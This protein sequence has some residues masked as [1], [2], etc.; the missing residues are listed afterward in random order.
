VAPVT[1]PAITIAKG[2]DLQTIPSG[3]TA[4]WTIT[5]TNSGDV[6]LT[7]V[8]VTDAEAPGCA[9][10]QADLPAL[11]SMAPGA[12]VSYSCSRANVGANFTNVAVAT[13]TPSGAADVTDDDDARV[14][15]LLPAIQVMKTPDSQQIMQGGTATF[16]IA[17]TNTGQVTLTNV[18]V[19]DAQAPGCA[20]TQ[21][22]LPGLASLASGALVTYSCTRANV[23]ESFTNVAVATGTPPFGS[24][25]TDD[26]DANVVVRVPHPAITIF[27]SP[28]RQVL[29]VGGTATFKIT[30]TNNGDVTLT[31]VTVTD[32]LTPDCN[33]SLG[34]LEPGQSITYTCT[35]KNVRSAFDNV[36][37]ATGTPPSGPNVTATDTAPVTVRAPATPPPPKKHPHKVVTKK[38]PKVTG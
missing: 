27:K 9:R 24:D 12:S 34:T 13:G 30:V 10:T 11:A 8:R 26:D 23:Q 32:A 38:K 18:R 36:A 19:T 15:I 20:R 37:V 2:P 28:K 17:V 6:A 14:Q 21:A 35:R 31:N 33:R 29:K 4:T 5:V 22:D 1:H 3:G 16:T 7:N 25:V